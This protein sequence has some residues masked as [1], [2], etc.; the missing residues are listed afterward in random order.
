[1]AEKKELV[2]Y[3]AKAI[4]PINSLNSLLQFAKIED[5]SSPG[6]ISSLGHLFVTL[7]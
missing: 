4:N 6:G 3:K 2:R 7:T 5:S 1:M